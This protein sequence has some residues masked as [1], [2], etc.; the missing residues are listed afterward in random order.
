MSTEANITSGFF[1][2]ED[3]ALVFTIKDAGGAVI[4]IT[5]WTIGFRMS[6]SQWGAASIIKAATLTTPASGICTVTLSSGDTSSL[7]QDGQPTTY[8][9]T[10]RRTDTGSRTELAY[11]QII[12]F[13]TFTD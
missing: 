7:T 8:Y 9:Y 1:R 11:G 4:N 3:K 12:I 6:Q 2:G 13:D 10:L 5:G